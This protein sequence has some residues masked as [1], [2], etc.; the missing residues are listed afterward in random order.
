MNVDRRLKNLETETGRLAPHKTVDVEARRIEWLLPLLEDWP[1]E[2]TDYTYL[3]RPV[4]EADL[5]DLC[6]SVFQRIRDGELR[7]FG[8]VLSEL[9]E[10]VLRGLK[11]YIQQRKADSE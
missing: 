6:R 11:K 10:Q 7:T 4:P 2:L 3:D 8:E 1:A 9:P 5:H